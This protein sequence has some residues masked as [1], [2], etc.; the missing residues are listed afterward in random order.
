MR[1]LFLTLMLTLTIC[2]GVSSAGGFIQLFKTG[3]PIVG[4]SYN[5]F[6]REYLLGNDGPMYIDLDYVLNKH[7]KVVVVQYKSWLRVTDNVWEWRDVSTS[8]Y[9]TNEALLDNQNLTWKN[10]FPW[11]SKRIY[12]NDG[13]HALKGVSVWGE[14]RE[15]GVAN[16]VGSFTNIKISWVR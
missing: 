8:Y 15:A 1:F 3:D 4:A 7:Y 11:E 5:A 9:L 6:D 12:F 14:C 2:V 16:D 10:I 13:D